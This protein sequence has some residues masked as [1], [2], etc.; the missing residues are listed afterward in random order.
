MGLS[1]NVKAAANNAVALVSYKFVGGPLANLQGVQITR[2]AGDGT[3]TI[4]PSETP[5]S[6][7]TGGTQPSNIWPIQK[8][9]RYYN[10]FHAAG[11]CHLRS[12]P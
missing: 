9:G 8:K 12:L 10:F 1:I 7:G 4:L 3:R 5:F 2:V 6:G 11:I